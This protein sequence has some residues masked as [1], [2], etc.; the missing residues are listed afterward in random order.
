M[1]GQEHLEITHRAF[2]DVTAACV[3][4]ETGAAIWAHAHKMRRFVQHRV[5]RRVGPRVKL[6]LDETRFAIAPIASRYRVL[7]GN[8]VQLQAVARDQLSELR[9][10]DFFDS[11][12]SGIV[13][14]VA[15]SEG[16]EVAGGQLLMLIC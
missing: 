11:P 2:F 14:E 12:V 15:V 6:I 13:E 3:A 10:V 8:M 1:I 16:T 4:L 5:D 9:L 7:V